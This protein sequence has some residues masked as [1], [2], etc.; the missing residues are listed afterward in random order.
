MS[1]IDAF[2][3]YQHEGTR[4]A[5]MQPEAYCHD[6]AK[7]VA[8]GYRLWIYNPDQG[9]EKSMQECIDFCHWFKEMNEADR[10][11]G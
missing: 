9:A 1:F 11:I 6:L 7:R 4:I 5:V 8:D 2:V 10:R 3:K